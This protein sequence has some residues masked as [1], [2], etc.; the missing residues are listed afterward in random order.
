MKVKRI[1]NLDRIIKATVRQMERAVAEGALEAKRTAETLVPVDKGDLKSTLE[2]DVT[3]P[4]HAE[5]SAGGP[6][7]ISEKTV[8]YAAAVEYGST[9][10]K[11]DGSI[12]TIPAQPYFRPGV[13]AGRRR[14][15]SE[16]KIKDR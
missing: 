4:G 8:N 2:A 6:S 14:L 1:S 10:R 9:H 3:R 16:M 7:K 13:D 15:R 12:Y 11:S 5:F